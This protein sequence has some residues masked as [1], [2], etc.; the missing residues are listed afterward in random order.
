MGQ[1]MGHAVDE[2]SKCSGRKV[3]DIDGQKKKNEQSTTIT[4][5]GRKQEPAIQ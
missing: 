4:K 1:W 2:Q 3:T 5:L